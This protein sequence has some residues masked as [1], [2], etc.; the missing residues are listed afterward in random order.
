MNNKSLVAD[1][2]EELKIQSV[3]KIFV[4]LYRMITYLK[5]GQKTSGQDRCKMESN[6]G[7]PVA[8]AQPVPFPWG[9]S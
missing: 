1:D 8:I 9:R 5:D 7:F 3:S 2:R 6:P 4:A